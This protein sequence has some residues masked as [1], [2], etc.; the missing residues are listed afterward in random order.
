MRKHK[1]LINEINLFGELSKTIKI[2]FTIFINFCRQISI[3]MF[4]EKLI[5]EDSIKKLIKEAHDSIGLHS[6]K[7]YWID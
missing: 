7:T 3:W 5:I 4:K 6:K 1:K 2:N